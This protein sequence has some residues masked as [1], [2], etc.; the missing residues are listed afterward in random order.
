MPELPEV[1]TTRRGVAPH[2]EGR[3]VTGVVV[4][5]RRFRQPVPENLADI[6]LGQRLGVV[7]HVFQSYSRVCLFSQ[8]PRRRRQLGFPGADPSIPDWLAI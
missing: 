7:R 6:L 1:E 8:G 3:C 4:R 2:L 5:E